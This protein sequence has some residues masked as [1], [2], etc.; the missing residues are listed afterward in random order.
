LF[1]KRLQ[2][3]CII[4]PSS[5]QEGQPFKKSLFYFCRYTALHIAVANILLEKTYENIYKRDEIVGTWP[6]L[7]FLQPMLFSSSHIWGPA[8]L[9]L[10]IIN[11]KDTALFQFRL[12]GEAEG[13]QRSTR[14]LLQGK[15]LHKKEGIRNAK[16]CYNT[17]HE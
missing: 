14:I 8:I 2:L 7:G 17:F 12:G 13:P 10:A 6:L 5:A 3:K 1:L 16:M 4:D 11:L 9:F 15:S